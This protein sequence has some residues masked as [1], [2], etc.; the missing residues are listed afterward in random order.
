MSNQKC[1]YLTLWLKHSCPSIW[2]SLS[3]SLSYSTHQSI[4]PSTCKAQWCWT[5]SLLSELT[6]GLPAH[7]EQS[8]TAQLNDPASQL[9]C[10]VHAIASCG[11]GLPTKH[12]TK[13]CCYPSLWDRYT[14]GQ[15]TAQCPPLST[16]LSSP[17]S[18]LPLSPVSLCSVSV[19]VWGVRVRLVKYSGL[20]LPTLSINYKNMCERSLDRQRPA[21]VAIVFLNAHSLQRLMLNAACCNCYELFSQLLPLAIQLSQVSGTYQWPE[22]PMSPVLK[23]V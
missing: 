13:Y 20:S 14:S 17:P 15:N 4:F 23:D 21:L 3:H 2:S 22:P 12:H 18:S 9:I 6:E 8:I 5:L 10:A 16:S 1:C 11:Q 19:L 7:T